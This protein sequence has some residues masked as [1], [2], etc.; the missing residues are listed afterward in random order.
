[1]A[2]KT[3][4]KGLIGLINKRLIPPILKE[5]NIDKN[6]QIAYLSNE[7][8]RRLANILTDWRFNI[9]GSKSFKDAQVTA[10]GE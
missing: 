5:V 2:K 1:M 9:S 7:E 6:K 4:E 8:V 3:I 10:G